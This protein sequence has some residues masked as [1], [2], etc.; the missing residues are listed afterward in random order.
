MTR[1]RGRTAVGVSLVLL[2]VA[3]L[4]PGQMLVRAAPLPSLKVAVNEPAP[5]FAL[6]LLSGEPIRLI[7][8][9]GKVLV[10]NFW[11]SW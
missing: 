1:G 4:V 7:D 5:D 10:L 3:A 8:F 11:A 9:R 6:T 2:T